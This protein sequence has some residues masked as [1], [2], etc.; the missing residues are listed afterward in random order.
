ME[1]L[2]HVSQLRL[3][4]VQGL[5]VPWLGCFLGRADRPL[6]LPPL[7]LDLLQL[8]VDRVVPRLLQMT[9]H[10]PLLIQTV[11]IGPPLSG[12]TSAF[13]RD[14]PPL[15]WALADYFHLFLIVLF[16]VLRDVLQVVLVLLGVALHLSHVVV[17]L[18]L[19]NPAQNLLVL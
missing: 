12:Q 18:L 10:G 7:Q 3:T 16:W 9:A 11:G 1:G 4:G 13:G 17:R 2:R 5:D 6:L 8:E 14:L 19:D 15:Y